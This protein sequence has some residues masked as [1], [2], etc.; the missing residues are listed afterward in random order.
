MVFRDMNV[1][2]NDNGQKNQNIL[3]NK[4]KQLVQHTITAYKITLR[5]KNVI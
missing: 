4:H 3:L 1:I 5:L 2:K